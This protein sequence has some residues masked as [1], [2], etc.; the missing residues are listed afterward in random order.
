MASLVSAT[1]RIKD[2]PSSLIDPRIV[3]ES[4]A[5]RKHH[6]RDRVL[7]PL[8]TLEA[9]ATQIA[10]GNT[11]MAH[12]VRLMNNE[13]SESAYCQARQRLPVEVF[14]DVLSATTARQLGEA[15]QTTGTW[16][17]HRTFLAD[18]TG[19][20][21]P[22]TPELQV[23]FG[24]PSNPGPGLGFPVGHVLVLL[25]APSALLL[26]MIVSPYATQD[27]T[28]MSEFHP[29]LREGDVV[30]TDRGICSY[31]YI[32]TLA[33][34]GVHV[35]C[36]AHRARP[37]T[38]P[39][40]SG[41]REKYAYGRQCRKTPILVERL[42]QQDQV[43]ELLKPRNRPKWMTAEA[44]AQIPATLTVRVLKFRISEP[45]FRTREIEIMTTLLD[46]A[47]PP[48]PAAD[49]AE[50]YLVRWRIEV[51]L[52][53]IKQT[54]GMTSLHSKTVEGVTKELLMFALVYNAVRSVMVQ[55]AVRQGVEPDRISFID[56]LRWITL[57][58]EGEPLPKLKVNPKR[59]GRHY[60]RAVK[61]SRRFRK[62]KVSR[63]DWKKDQL[64]K[65]TI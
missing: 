45:G 22:E 62:L 9:F 11:A 21:M 50:L 29:Y 5:N 38:Y 34:R 54:L 35:V 26:D 25:D 1:L 23:Y 14:R 6:W 33:A 42:G 10:H 44:F 47:K 39:A 2:N 8:R 59:S 30:I 32:A 63:A 58:Q 61:R 3:A 36:R 7:S 37:M 52:R 57:R 24:Q 31:T 56:A 19:P 16:K 18:G 12:V 46:A 55:A 48:H 40:S 53:H 20:D 17:G 28:K 64:A 51:N 13:F 15:R 43:V 49:I 65:R 4:C 41:P 60:E 27:V